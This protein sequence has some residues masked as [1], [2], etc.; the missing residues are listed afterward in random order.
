M[1]NIEESGIIK[2][3]GKRAVL[4]SP[5]SSI[6]TR[7]VIKPMVLDNPWQDE[8]P[9]KKQHGHDHTE[10]S[11]SGINESQYYAFILNLRPSSG[12]FQT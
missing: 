9:G 4:S 12:A 6:T 5:A 10:L 2:H 11:S 7:V 1:P 3:Q 8:H